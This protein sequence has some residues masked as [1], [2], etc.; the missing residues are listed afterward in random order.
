ML[1]FF[2]RVYIKVSDIHPCDIWGVFV[3]WV[4]LNI[5]LDWT[6][7][8]ADLDANVVLP[9]SLVDVASRWTLRKSEAWKCLLFLT[10]KKNFFSFK[11]TYDNFS[12]M[13]SGNTNNALVASFEIVSTTEST[14]AAAAL[15]SEWTFLEVVSFVFHFKISSWLLFF[16][17]KR[18]ELEFFPI[19]NRVS[20]LLADAILM[21]AES[22]QANN[23]F[24]FRAENATSTRSNGASPGEH[25]RKAS[26]KRHKVRVSS[27]RSVIKAQN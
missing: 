21:L 12:N 20:L 2:S 9:L 3:G 22:A 16:F 17:C 7:H 27:R 4:E 6:H 8:L 18:S 23:N 13:R 11:L 19:T 25:A 14:S 24:Q 10:L 26:G 5:L 15:L 1:K